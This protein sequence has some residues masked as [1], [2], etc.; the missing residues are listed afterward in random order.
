ME[1]PQLYGGKVPVVMYVEKDV[2][3]KI[4]AKRGKESR[5]SF[6]NRVL[7]KALQTGVR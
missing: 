2:F 1:Y 4:E 5:N 7:E 3:A 6:L